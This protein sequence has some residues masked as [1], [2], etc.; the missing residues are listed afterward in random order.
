MK[1]ALAWVGMSAFIGGNDALA[2]IFA[3]ALAGQA[4]RRSLRS[5]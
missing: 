1:P 3:Q 5:Q 2:A 4:C